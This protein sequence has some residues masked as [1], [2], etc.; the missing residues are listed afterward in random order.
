METVCHRAFETNHLWALL[1]TS[2]DIMDFVS[3]ARL[4]SD[5]LPGQLAGP[6]QAFVFVFLKVKQ[7]EASGVQGAAMSPGRRHGAGEILQGCSPQLL[8][9]P[10]GELAGFEFR[11]FPS[12]PG[13][14]LA[15]F[16]LGR[17]PADPEGALA[18]FESWTSSEV[19]AE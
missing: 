13:G 5:Y 3:S 9:E 12:E 2:H 11:L 14:E 16:G 15:G 7:R 8:P 10:G 6:N 1:K 19:E 17:F 4:Y 18:G